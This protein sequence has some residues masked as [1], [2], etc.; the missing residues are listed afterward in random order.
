MLRDT[1]RKLF[2]FYLVVD[3]IINP[4]DLASGKSSRCLEMLMGFDSFDNL[5]DLKLTN[6]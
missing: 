6:V 2:L 4:V 1:A 5:T 3:V